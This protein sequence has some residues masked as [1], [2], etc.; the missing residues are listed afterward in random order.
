MVDSLRRQVCLDGGEF[1]VGVLTGLEADG[2]AQFLQIVAR[3]N[4]GC[5]S[6]L[7]FDKNALWLAGFEL[8]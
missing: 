1:E 4:A 2:A 5:G 3:S 7:T 6:A 8:L